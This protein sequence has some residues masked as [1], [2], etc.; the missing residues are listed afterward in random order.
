MENSRTTHWEQVYTEK[1]N[2]ELSWH[3]EDPATSLDL[4]NLAGVTSESSVID[5]GGGTSCLSKRLMEQGL[6]DLTVLDLSPAALASTRKRLGP[7]GE[8]IDWIVADVTTWEPRRHYDLWHDRAAFHFLTVPID[9]FAYIDRLL[10][11]LR[12][13]GHAVIASFASNGP[14]TCSGLPVMRYDPKTLANAL[15]RSFAPVAFRSHV[16]LTPWGSAQSFQYGLFR[17][18]V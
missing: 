2:A 9:R 18:V 17:K 6:R 4:A 1:S 3:Q 5:I 11:C 15:G 7:L 10:R 14:E 16:H 8:S 13:G 12:P